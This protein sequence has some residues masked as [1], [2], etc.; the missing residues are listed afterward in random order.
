MQWYSNPVGF[1]DRNA[2]LPVPRSRGVDD[3]RPIKRERLSVSR[4][5]LKFTLV[6]S[7]LTIPAVA[8]C[9]KATREEAMPTNRRRSPKLE[10]FMAGLRLRGFRN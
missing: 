6:A 5:L 1:L 10:R 8:F 3:S 9:S 2:S 7:Y 4:R